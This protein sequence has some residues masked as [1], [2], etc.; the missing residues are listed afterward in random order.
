MAAINLSVR[1]AAKAASPATLQR[2]GSQAVL[3]T[4]TGLAALA[5]FAIIFLM[6]FFLIAYAYPAIRFNG[7]AFFTSP[8]WNIGNQYGSATVSRAGFT[9]EAGAAFGALVFIFGS[10]LTALLTMV[11]AVP[12]SLMVALSLV[13][14]IPRMIRPLANALVEL[15]AGVPSVVYG[16]WGMVVLVPWIGG[17]LAP[18]VTTHLGFIPFL[19]GSAGSGN[20]L[21]ASVFILSLMVIPIMVATTRDVILAQS[22]SLFEASMA[23]GSTSWQAMVRAVLPSVRKGIVASVLLAFGR[24]LGETMAV[25]MVCGAAINSFP[26]NVFSPV[27]TIAAVIV[28]QLESALTDAS[29]MAQRSLAELACVLF[30]ITLLVNVIAR[31]IMRG[32]DRREGGHA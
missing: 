26:Q 12:L 17:A 5:S 22:N 15:M 14:R 29:G 1:G 6:L 9:A 31:G 19:G 2:T 25:L 13:Y 10:A 11:V 18:W 23:L 24:A 7:I 20:G 3:R 8:I 27:N 4:L 21:A 28:S 32:A 30:I 16:L